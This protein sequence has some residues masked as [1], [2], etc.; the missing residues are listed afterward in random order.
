MTIEMVAIG[1]A[2]TVVLTRCIPPNQAYHSTDAK[3][4]VFIAGGLPM[5]T[6]M[7]KSGT[8]NLI[9]SWLHRVVVG[10]PDSLILLALFAGLAVIPQFMS[11]AATKALLPP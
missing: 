8:A 7:Q 2:I 9:A 4:Y 10:W 11:D 6:V 1:G 3:I 5:G